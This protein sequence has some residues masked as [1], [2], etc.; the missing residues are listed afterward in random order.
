MPDAQMRCIKGGQNS[1][2]DALA[3]ILTEKARSVVEKEYTKANGWQCLRKPVEEWENGHFVYLSTL[4]DISANTLKRIYGHRSH[5]NETQNMNKCT[6]R[7]IAAF[8]GTDD[9]DELVYARISQNR[10]NAK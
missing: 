1:Y 2:H 7:K 9:L 4:L 10:G 8:L 3:Q 6:K 5:E